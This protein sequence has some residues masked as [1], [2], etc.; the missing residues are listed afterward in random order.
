M[1]SKFAPIEK[2]VGQRD[3]LDWVMNRPSPHA[4]GAFEMRR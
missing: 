4:S 1:A 3:C 2:T